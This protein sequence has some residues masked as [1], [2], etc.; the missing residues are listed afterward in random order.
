[1]SA[2]RRGARK[3]R[4]S[5]RSRYLHERVRTIGLGRGAAV[6][7]LG[8][9]ATRAGWM[10]LTDSAVGAR[11][12]ATPALGRFDCRR[13]PRGHIGHDARAAACRVHQSK[14]C[15]RRA[16]G[17]SERARRRSISRGRGQCRESLRA[18]RSPW[19]YR[20]QRSSRSAEVS[21]VVLRPGATRSVS[22]HNYGRR[23]SPPAA[24]RQAASGG[25]GTGASGVERAS[26][27]DP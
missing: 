18:P 11:P 21:S 20:G 24:L 27:G 2:P 25:A 3:A 23:G 8:G 15:R 13:Q 1:M 6:N 9:C 16:G 17:L 5:A 4:Q 26:R 10:L 19:T 12:Q 7:V 22:C 14:K